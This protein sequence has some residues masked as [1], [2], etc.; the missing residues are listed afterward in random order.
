MTTLKENA[1]LLYRVMLRFLR[2]FAAGGLSA[3]IVQLA[4][5]PKIATLEDLKTYTFS[6]LVGFLAGGIAALDKTIR[7]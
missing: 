3:V 7:G 4:L 6:V 1:S 5:V 2:I